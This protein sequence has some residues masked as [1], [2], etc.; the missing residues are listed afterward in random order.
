MIGW[1]PRQLAATRP[2]SR[3]CGRA[4]RP[5]AARQAGA[6]PRT[7]LPGLASHRTPPVF[8]KR[9]CTPL[10]EHEDHG[11]HVRSKAPAA[12]PPPG[13]QRAGAHSSAAGPLPHTVPP[14]ACCRA[15]PRLAAECVHPVF[16][17][18]E[19]PPL[20]LSRSIPWP[21]LNAAPSRTCPALPLRPLLASWLL[22]YAAPSC[23]PAPP[24]RLFYRCPGCRSP[25]RSTR[26]RG[27]AAGHA[28]CPP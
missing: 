7:G 1:P 28:P 17:P 14:S 21:R 12:C 24:L 26:L 10:R 8:H 19:A 23:F 27:A 2:A 18:R 9:G 22:R 4:S 6:T 3:L 13:R 16:L 25:P 11:Q 5:R 20:H 15:A